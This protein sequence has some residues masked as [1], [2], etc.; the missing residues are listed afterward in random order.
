MRTTSAAALSL[1]VVAATVAVTLPARAHISLNFPKGRYFQ[2]TGMQTD[3][4]KQKN[5][6]CGVTG[7]SRTKD[8]SLIT[9]FKPGEKVMVKF[10]ETIQHP[11]HFEIS[12]DSDGQDFPFPGEAPSATSGVT[13]LANNIADKTTNDYTYEVTLP[14]MECEK[15]TLQLVQVMTTKSPPYAKTG[16]LYFQCADIAIK[17]GGGGA[18]GASSG[19]AAGTTGGMAGNSSGTG[20]SNNGG[21]Q[22]GGAS[23]GLSSGG[24]SGSGSSGSPNGGAANGSGGTTGVGTGGSNGVSTGGSTG[25]FATGGLTAT[26]GGVSTATGGAPVAGTGGIVSVPTTGGAAATTGGVTGSPPGSAEEEPGCSVS[27]A[28]RSSAPVSLLALAGLFAWQRRRR[29]ALA[30]RRR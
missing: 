15:C 27:H 19:G 26:T 17:A 8:A 30:T 21:T 7:D 14:N 5:G 22:A 11:G 6:P 24:A 16:D 4:N 29:G 20:G 25:G 1:V 12:F 28:P 10:Q 9:T 3:Q 13:V 2:T 23:G 18:G